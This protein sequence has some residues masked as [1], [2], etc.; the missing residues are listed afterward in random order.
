MA[1]RWNFKIGNQTAWFA[2]SITEPFE[3]A[4][5][6]GFDA[7]EWFPDKKETGDGWSE[8]DLSEETRVYIMDTAIAAGIRL[9][10]HVPWR[11]NPFTPGSSEEMARATRLADDIGAAVMNIHFHNKEGAAAFAEAIGPLIDELSRKKMRLSIEN[12]PETAPEDFNE[13]FRLLAPGPAE[14]SA[15][16]M[17]LD[18]GHAN[19]CSKTRNDYLRYIDLLDRELPVIHVHLH[20]N[21]GDSDRHLPLFTGPSR[22][23]DAG[24]RGFIDRMK[25]RG[26]SGSLILEQWPDPP[27]LING[28]RHRLLSM[29]GI[30]RE[31][32]PRP[33]QELPAG[34]FVGSIAKADRKRKSWREKLGWVHELFSD[35]A[36]DLTTEQLVYLAIYLRFLGTGQVKST[37]DGSHYRPSHH[38]RMARDIFRRLSRL[39]TPENAF[40]L[41]KIYPW[42][43][44]FE[45]EFLRP[46]P[47]T[48]IRDIAHRNDIPRELKLRIKT[49]LQNKLH[50]NAGPD[51]LE[52]S[53]H[54]LEQITS[55]GA[56]YPPA[57]VE[58]FRKFHLELREFFNA[59]SLDE[60]LASIAASSGKAEASVIKRFTEAKASAKTTEDLLAVLE[61]LTELRRLFANRLTGGADSGAQEVQAAD[62]GLEDY[63][64]VLLG[65]I[66]ADLGSKGVVRWD[67]A[68]RCLPMIVYNLGMSGF[69]EEE[70]RAIASEIEAWRQGF[71]AERRDGLL[72]L[73]ATVDRSLRL[74]E[75][76]TRKI[77]SLFQHRAGELG[78]ALGVDPR[79]IKVFTESEI[80]SHPVFQLS[81]LAAFLL[82]NIRQKAVLPPWDIIVP[83][84]TTGTIMFASALLS[85]PEEPSGRPVIAI[86]EKVDGDEEIPPSVKAIVV[87]YETP[88]LSHLAVRAR[89]EGVVFV[90]CEEEDSFAALKRLSGKAVDFDV[91][92]NNVRYSLSKNPMREVPSR[93][94][95]S[96]IKLP[97][98]D[99]A[100]TSGPISLDFSTQNNSGAKA[101]GA[102]R[103]RDLSL[104]AG[105]GFR[106]PA[107]VVIPFGLME[108]SLKEGS[109]GGRE[110]KSLVAE[111][112]QAG[113][114]VAKTISGRIMEIISEIELPPEV[115]SGVMEMLGPGK[116]LMVRSSSNCEDLEKLSGAGLYETVSNV[117]EELAGDAIR[118]VWASLWSERAVT[119]RTQLGIPHGEAR[120]AV[121]IQ[122]MAVPDYS[123]IIHTVN[124]VTRRADEV[125]IE[126]AAGLGE[127][128][129]SG[130]VPGT[131]Y[132]MV[133]DKKNGTCNMLS[134]A[135][136]SRAYAPGSPGELASRVVD[137]SRVQLSTDEAFRAA[138]GKRL[139]DVSVFV[140]KNLGRPQ[141]I[142]GV[143]AGPEIYLVQSRAQQGVS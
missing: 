33:R 66:I 119:S 17:C 106:T 88:H 124:P 116:R 130:R 6:N 143:I 105:S 30:P 19:L 84:R 97:A 67:Y 41:R 3:Y 14:T 137:Y 59:R 58:E 40:I 39:A 57:F 111:L 61:L 131:P 128:L 120:M 46:E 31:A 80:R 102:K 90:A 142:E 11:W 35:G 12:T 62:T 104:H 5:S 92:G 95:V 127:A 114:N 123:F 52:T 103:L 10:V 63:F 107:G 93:S 125:Y 117:T 36:P 113:T 56:N 4:L 68:L 48:R 91:E 140:E 101:F 76:Y 118:T 29:I 18:L 132:R 77:L 27:R 60:R 9:S 75:V 49:T 74:A 7:F 44:S 55:P 16:G 32:T 23:D 126:L 135:S 87:P 100:A 138:A 42:L 133:C 82:G 28:A 79:A 89:Q 51:D 96:P 134:F 50:R 37:E 70:C 21:Y 8:E 22:R 65:R 109:E 69:D 25:Q 115:V 26:F 34:D 98:V 20:E 13:L 1:E 99:M 45:S 94:N 139:T 110:Y 47:L 83:G 122:E 53:S 54:L 86:L 38:A 136:F 71:D 72:R 73:K 24:I 108:A 64:F 121:L 43:P 15:V 81:R 129:A 112:D 78:S 2:P 85:L 141:D